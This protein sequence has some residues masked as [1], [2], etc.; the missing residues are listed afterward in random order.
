LRENE[1]PKPDIKNKE[2][3]K[4]LG[5]FPKMCL[6]KA[7][8]SKKCNILWCLKKSP[9]RDTI[10]DGIDNSRDKFNS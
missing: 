6:T 5:Y 9:F 10:I 1:R 2:A 7:E 8:F 3:V 4:A